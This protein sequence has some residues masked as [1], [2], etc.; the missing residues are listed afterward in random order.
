MLDDP[1]FWLKKFIRR[2]KISKKNQKAWTKAIQITKNT[3]LENHVLSYLQKSTKNEEMVDDL[4]CFIEFI[5]EEFLAKSDEIMQG[6]L[7]KNADD[8]NVQDE[9]GWPSFFWFWFFEIN[10]LSFYSEIDP[11]VAIIVKLY[12]YI[13]NPNLIYEDGF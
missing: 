7:R 10:L 4:H 8:P 12:R 11:V 5:N 13:R 3:Y 9:H 6:Y 2:G 1:I